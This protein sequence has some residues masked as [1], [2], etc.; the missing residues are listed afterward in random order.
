V[1]M[2]AVS[3]FCRRIDAGGLRDRFYRLNLFCGDGLTAALV[4][5]YRAESRTATARGNTTD[6]NNGPF[7]SAD[8]N[9]TGSSSGLKGNGTSK[10][11]NTGIAGNSITASNIHLGVGLLATDTRAAAFHGAMGTFNSTGSLA[12][13]L[14]IRRTNSDRNCVAGSF[15]SPT[16]AYGEQVQSAALAVG[17]M[18]MTF[19][20]LYR[21]G[22]ATGTTGTAATNYNA[23]HSIYVFA[24]NNG[25]SFQTAASHTDSRFGWYSVGLH[26]TS[27]QAVTFHDAIAAFNTALSRT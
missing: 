22:S 13:T 4:P 27:A 10:F 20:T 26:M 1:T 9:N 21:N 6:T 2:S 25:A 15:G 3:Q 5:L 24:V 8:Y 17:N 14:E 18:L 7:V 16:T 12:Y 23:A 11:L 19:P